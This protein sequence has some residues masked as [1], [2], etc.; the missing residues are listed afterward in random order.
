MPDRGTRRAAASQSSISLA[1]DWGTRFSDDGKT[2]WF[3]ID[4]TAATTEIHDE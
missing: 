4:A 1:D 3:T 2:V